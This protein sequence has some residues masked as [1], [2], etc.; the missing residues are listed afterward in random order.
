MRLCF[1]ANLSIH[2]QRLVRFFVQE[3]DQ[4]HVI[5]FRAPQVPLPAGATLHDLT[6]L[7]DVRKLR[8]PVWV[9]AVRRIVRDLRPDVLHAHQIASAGWLGAAAGYHPFVA[10]AW[11]SDLMVGARRSRMQRQ[12]ARWVLARA[13][14]V[15]CVSHDLAGVALSLGADP[16]RLEVAPWGVDLAVFHPAADRAALREGLGLGPGPVVLSARS[17]K[18]VYRPLDLAHAIPH[19]L[20]ALPSARFLVRTHNSDPALLAQFQATVRQAGAEQAVRYIG[21]LEESAVADLYRAADVVVS[22]PASDGTPSSV[23]EA[24]ACGA[25][26]VVS[27]VPSL[28]E[29]VEHGREALFVPVGDTDG[30]ARSILSLLSDG[31]LRSQMAGSGVD[32]VRRRADSRVWMRRNAAIYRLLVPEA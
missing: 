17:V 19:V 27:D 9:R 14:Y 2:T 30:I 16:L 1:I 20:R 23:L 31:A 32:L 6:A 5:G 29:W 10:T 3:G 25:V 13:D 22:V 11:G 8:W 15:T 12:L 24:M 28:H 18:A 26:P 21:D 4:V 7:A